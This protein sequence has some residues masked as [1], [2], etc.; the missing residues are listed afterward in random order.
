MARASSK[1]LTRRR[2][3]SPGAGCLDWDQPHRI[4]S[5]EHIHLGALVSGGVAARR[6]GHSSRSRSA[7]SRFDRW[8]RTIEGKAQ[9][10][11]TGKA[12]DKEWPTRNGQ[13]AG[14][15]RQGTVSG[16]VAEMLGGHDLS[17]A[18]DRCRQGLRMPKRLARWVDHET[19]VGNS[20]GYLFR[21]WRI[22]DSRFTNRPAARVELC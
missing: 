21:T 4:S 12:Y 18:V 1:P 7:R 15:R 16:R 14:P 19:V 20:A 10:G 9:P 11:V 6:S 2:F 3:C 13:L 17:G 22:S 5:G 8:R